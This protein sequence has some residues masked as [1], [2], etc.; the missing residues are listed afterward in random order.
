MNES[1]KV[2]T[3]EK[4]RELSIL[5]WK[6]IYHK[7]I[8]VGIDVGELRARILYLEKIKENVK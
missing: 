8:V 7:L 5:K 2:K 6:N 1:G 4:A 3:Y